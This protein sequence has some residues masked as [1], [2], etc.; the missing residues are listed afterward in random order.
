MSKQQWI[1][2]HEFDM[3]SAGELIDCIPIDNPESKTL[4]GNTFTLSRIMEMLGEIDNGIYKELKCY[5]ADHLFNN[6]Q[7]CYIET[8]RKEKRIF[9]HFIDSGIIEIGQFTSILFD[10]MEALTTCDTYDPCPY[11]TLAEYLGHK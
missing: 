8:R 4:K 11:D 10:H 6:F 2:Q 9:F 1:N 7:D 3:Q 5:F